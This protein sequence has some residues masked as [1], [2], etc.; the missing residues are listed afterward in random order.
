MEKILVVS[1]LKDGELKKNTLELLC[2]A[3]NMGLE[4][5]AVLIGDRVS[6]QADKLAEYGAKTVY[7]AEDPSLRMFNTLAYTGIIQDAAAQSGASQIWFSA[8]ETGGDL[9]PRIAARLRVGAIT[10]ITRLKLEGRKITAYHPA[11]ASKVIQECGFTKD[12][13]RV[14]SMR[15]GSFNLTAPEKSALNIVKLSIPEMDLRAVVREVIADSAQG[16]D[17]A[18]A[19][20]IVSVGRGVKDS[21]GVEFVRPLVEL[22]G[23]GYGST[24]GA[25][26][27]GL[28]PHEAQVGQT[29]KKVTPALYFALGIS[30]AIQ[31]LA[32]MTG[33]TFIIAVN[34]DP[35]APIFN[36]AD[37]GIVG[38]LFKAVPV[39]VKEI[40]KIKQAVQ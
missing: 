39:L 33:S 13:L 40:S 30:G 25:C 27:A 22:L 17:L 14:L 18:E 7:L 2:L 5:S 23:A 20:I 24:R 36:V 29:G 32:G 28:M 19:K 16:V 12:G 10:D 3:N 38:D 8:T 31:H 37:Y 34:T 15:P 11:M 26:D 9:A 1:E 4:A 35:E 6:G 21:D